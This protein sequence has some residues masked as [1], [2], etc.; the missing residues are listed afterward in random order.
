MLNFGYTPDAG[1]L[2]ANG[3]GGALASGA[4]A[5]DVLSFSVVNANNTNAPVTG[6][7]NLLVKAANN[8]P[9]IVTALPDVVYFADSTI[10]TESAIDLTIADAD[11][12]ANLFVSNA[13]TGGRI[14]VTSDNPNLI[15][16][17]DLASAISTGTTNA[18]TL[19][20]KH[21]A[22]ITLSLIHI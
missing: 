12:A 2:N 21:Q 1:Y 11:T 5:P 16:P 19:T 15:L 13:T 20:I 9:R 7:L 17:A 8:T 22:N 10:I 14:T 4:I 18:R 3:T 6:S